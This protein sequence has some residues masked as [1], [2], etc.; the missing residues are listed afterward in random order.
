MS[1]FNFK[2][3]THSIF[4]LIYSELHSQQYSELPHL[5]KTQDIH[6][7]FFQKYLSK[8][9]KIKTKKNTC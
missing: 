2:F 9:E 7:Q 5:Q 6:F 8:F 1:K 4:P 3:F